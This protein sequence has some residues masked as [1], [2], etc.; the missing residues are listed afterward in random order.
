MTNNLDRN[1]LQ[2]LQNSI[3]YF[4][5]YVNGGTVLLYSIAYRKIRF[6]ICLLLPQGAYNFSQKISSELP[7]ILSRGSNT[8]L[9]RKALSFSF[10]G[11]ILEWSN[12]SFGQISNIAGIL[13]QNLFISPE[14]KLCTEGEKAAWDFSSHKVW[15]PNFSAWCVW[16]HEEQLK[17]KSLKLRQKNTSH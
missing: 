14:I 15:C 17:E 9:F 3:K 11:N 13:C 16:F 10:N 12:S 4:Q 8:R 2:Q 1:L 6:W 7:S 5:S